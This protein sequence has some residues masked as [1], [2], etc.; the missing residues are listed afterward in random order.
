MKA[1]RR[2]VPPQ[3][4]DSKHDDQDDNDCSDADKHG[5]L[6]SHAAASRDGVV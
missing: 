4:H 5:L 6:L 2:S 1:N 3:E